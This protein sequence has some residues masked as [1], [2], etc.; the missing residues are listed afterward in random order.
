[1]AGREAR[2][3]WPNDVRVDGRKVAGIL[4]ERGAGS[5][6]GIGLNVNPVEGDFPDELRDSA[7]SLR[8]LAGEVLD[9]SELAREVIRRLDDHYTSAM[10]DGP[11]RLAAA[12]RERL[13][14]MGREVS[15]ATREGTVRGILVE[16]DLTGGLRIIDREGRE[17]TVEHAEIREVEPR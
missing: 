13:E 6:V 4:V 1:M 9:R 8:I 3:K 5:V 10:H 11:S 7:T 14:P 17:R 12:W 15:L 2:I 16:A